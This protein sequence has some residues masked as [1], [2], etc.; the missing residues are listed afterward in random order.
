MFVNERLSR[1]ERMCL[2]D[3]EREGVCVKWCERERERER[4]CLGV[5]V[6]EQERY[7]YMLKNVCKEECV[8]VK[9]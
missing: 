3:K 1:Y 2:C 4:E 6:R 7:V 5:S 8:W 9:K